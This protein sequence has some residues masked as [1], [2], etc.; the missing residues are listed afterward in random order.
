MPFI[1]NAADVKVDAALNPE[2][3]ALKSEGCVVN[4][5]GTKTYFSGTGANE[6]LLISVP[7]E[8]C[9]GGNNWGSIVKVFSNYQ[10]GKWTKSKNVNVTSAQN[11]KAQGNGEFV[12]TSTEYGPADPHCC[13]SIHK[14]TV[15]KP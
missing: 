7:F 4:K 11:V 9:G 14:K 3:K 10:N 13:P 15:V 6:S 8:G 2:Y 12:I 1:S 5:K